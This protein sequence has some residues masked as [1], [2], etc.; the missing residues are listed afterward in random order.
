V[1]VLDVKGEEIDE[2]AAAAAAAAVTAA[3]AWAAAAAASREIPKNF[4]NPR[5]LNPLQR[6]MTA[7]AAAAAAGARVGQRGTIAWRCDQHPP[8]SEQSLCLN[9][10][11]R[12]VLEA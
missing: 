7:A 9:R 5:H 11:S 2:A 8:I 3:V 4:Q 12:V 10:A 6:K 1:G